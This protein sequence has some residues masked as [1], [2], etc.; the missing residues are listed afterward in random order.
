M[1]TFLIGYWSLGFSLWLLV[2]GY[3]VLVFGFWSLGFSLWYEGWWL[4]AFATG[5]GVEATWKQKPLEIEK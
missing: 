3:W 5:D 1:A 2:I 4:S